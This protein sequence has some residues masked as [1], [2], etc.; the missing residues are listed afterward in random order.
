MKTPSVIVLLT[1][2]VL[3]FIEKATLILVLS[4][5]PPSCR[6]LSFLT[7][8]LGFWGFVQGYL[9]QHFLIKDR[10][11]GGRRCAVHTAGCLGGPRGT[12]RAEIQA[13]QPCCVAWASPQ[14]SFSIPR[15]EGCHQCLKYP[16]Q[17]VVRTVQWETCVNAHQSTCQ[18]VGTSE[19]W[20][21]HSLHLHELLAWAP[22]S[23]AAVTKYHRQAGFK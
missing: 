5:P 15:Q 1:I 18:S 22:L 2:T 3:Y 14:A 9:F 19:C 21:Y 23:A 4:T 6:P 8:D 13:L 16:T 10:W 11:H 20:R 17:R 7:Y 12:G